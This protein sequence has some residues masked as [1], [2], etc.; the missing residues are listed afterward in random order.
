MTDQ[1]VEKKQTSGAHHHLL[2]GWRFR[3][4]IWTIMVTVIGY[5]LF[6]IW[7]GWNEVVHG[8]ERVGWLGIGLALLLSIFNFAVRFLRWDLFLIKLGHR[9]PFWP[10]LRIYLSGYALTTTPGKTGEAVRSVFLI[11][12]GVP[13]RESFG[14]FLSERFSDV[15]AG[16]AVSI[17]GLWA[18]PPIRPVLI[19]LILAMLVSLY[20]IQKDNWMR[21][22]EKKVNERWHGR[23]GHIIEFL[24]ETILAFRS[25]FKPWML[26]QGTVLG[27]LAWMAQGVA[28]YYMLIA[29]GSDVPLLTALFIYSFSLLIG[30]LTFL[31]GGLGGFEVTAVQLLRINDVPTST[32]VAVT[33][34]IRLT[35]IWFSVLVGLLALPKK[36]IEITK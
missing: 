10:N 8:F 26:I 6:T 7:G 21:A 13:Y 27:M 24:I 19:G 31:P 5:F 2:S 36:E 9:V 11:D 18:H 30:G 14:A 22:I 25:C 23:F 4:L 33:I 20:L 29:L 3:A 17:L 12:Y 34:V 28:F 35:T 15:L 32:A 1:E 16:I